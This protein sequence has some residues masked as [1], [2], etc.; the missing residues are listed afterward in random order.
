MASLYD[1]IIDEAEE[2]A[3]HRVLPPNASREE[4]VEAVSEIVGENLSPTTTFGYLAE[5][6]YNRIVFAYAEAS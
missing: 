2:L 1:Q 4:I 6:A 5:A 3:K